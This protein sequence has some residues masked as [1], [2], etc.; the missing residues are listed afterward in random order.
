MRAVKSRP[1]TS[2]PT[3]PAQHLPQWNL[4]DLLDD[5]ERHFTTLTREVDTQVQRFEGLREALEP[6]LSA[7]RFRD[8]LRLAEAITSTMNR[9]G[10]YAYLWFSEDTR[11]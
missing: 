3:P 2:R 10:A 4:K 6:E 8:S 5:P 7:E 9:L 1:R 11:H